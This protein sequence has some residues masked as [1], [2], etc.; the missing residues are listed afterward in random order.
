MVVHPDSV[1]STQILYFYFYY[2]LLVYSDFL[3]GNL[4]REVLL[5][6]DGLSADV[7]DALVEL[8]VLLGL[9]DLR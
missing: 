5:H 1:L 7:D 3:L 8:I 9:P 6:Y 4:A 2:L